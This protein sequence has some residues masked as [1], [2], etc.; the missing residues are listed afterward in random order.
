MNT[1][2]IKPPENRKALLDHQKVLPGYQ[3]AAPI[4]RPQSPGTL[5]YQKKKYTPQEGEEQNPNS[6]Q[7][8]PKGKCE[9]VCFFPYNTYPDNHR[10]RFNIRCP[11]FF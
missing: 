1:P 7:P 5:P 3:S 4:S 11:S 2:N 8:Q 6:Q 9:S 10:I